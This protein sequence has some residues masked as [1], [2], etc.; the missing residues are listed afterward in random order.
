MQGKDIR[1]I[2]LTENY[3]PQRGGMSQ[4]CD[5][6]IRN[7]RNMNV[8][9]DIIHFTKRNNSFKKIQ[10]V[11]G[12]YLNV[13]FLADEAHTVNCLWNFICQDDDYSACTHIV[14]FGGYLPIL[15]SPILSKWLSLPLVCLF[16]GNDFDNA[17][18]SSRKLPILERAIQQT[19]IITTVTSDMQDKIELIYPEKKVKFIPNSIETTNWKALKSDYEFANKFKSK[20]IDNKLVIGLFGH[21]KAKKGSD[22][23]LKCIAKSGLLEKIH[24]IIVGE[25]ETHIDTIVAAY[26]LHAS[27][28][29]F[30]DRYELIK[31]YLACDIVALPSFYDG[32]PNVLL[33]ASAL[34]IPVLASSVGGMKDVL[35]D[36]PNSFIFHPGNEAECIETLWR[37]IDTSEKERKEIG[38]LQKEILA[39]SFTSQQET[40]AYLSIFKE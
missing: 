1:I 6:I 7:L 27:F 24:L 9:I 4:S 5:R 14:A 28:L 23:L 33:E 34:S 35:A 10:Q 22:F 26:N 36:I 32:M 38:V 13:P 16:R 12:S 21:L 15:S 31:Y 19:Q 20:H 2:W 29:P 30:L 25:R 11:K 8:L 39:S 18:F 37:L 17:I 3:P 40:E